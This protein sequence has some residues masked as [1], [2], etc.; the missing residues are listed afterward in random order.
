MS[1]LAEF[2]SGTSKLIAL[3]GDVESDPGL[4]DK[5]AVPVLRDLESEIFDTVVPNLEQFDAQWHPLGFMSFKL[6]TLPD[7]GTL[8]LHIWPEG[9]RRESPRGPKIHDHA[10]HLSSLVLAGTYIDTLYEVEEVAGSYS[11]D[12]RNESGLLRVYKPK[13]LTTS[14]FLDTDGSCAKAAAYQTREIPAGETHAIPVHTFHTTDVPKAIFASTLM[15]ESPRYNDHTRILM[16]TPVGPLTDPHDP[17]PIEDIF[18]A[19]EQLM[20]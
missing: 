8:R 20:A 11:E 17:M 9:L 10:W 3:E 6:G 13:L 19:K 1:Y 4:F 5:Q 18:Y 2:Q 14:A 16:D 7:F 15:L 12:E